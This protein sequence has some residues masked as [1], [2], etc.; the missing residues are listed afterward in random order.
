MSKWQL[1]FVVLCNIALYCT[2]LCT[3]VRHWACP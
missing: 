1:L 3:M 2:C